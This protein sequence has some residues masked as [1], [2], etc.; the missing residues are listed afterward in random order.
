[1]EFIGYGVIT[2][3]FITL[4]H[5]SYV[6]TSAQ[7]ISVYRKE[8]KIKFA[9]SSIVGHRE[10]TK[11]KL[12]SVISTL[13]ATSSLASPRDTSDWHGKLPRKIYSLKERNIVDAQFWHPTTQQTP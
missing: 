6:P 5:R 11:H 3:R 4:E 10:L 12:Q 2:I 8:Q 9:F 1:M 13:A 7:L